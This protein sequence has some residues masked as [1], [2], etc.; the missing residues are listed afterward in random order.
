MCTG[1]NISWLGEQVLKQN[2]QNKT[3]KEQELTNKQTKI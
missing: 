3:N 2:K 1:R